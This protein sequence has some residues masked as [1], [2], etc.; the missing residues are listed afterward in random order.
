M[1]KPCIVLATLLLLTACMRGVVY[2]HYEHT[3]VSGW[4]KIDTLSYSVPRLAEGGLYDVT[5]GLRVNSKYP[6]QS[7]TLIVEQQAFPSKKTHI[8]TLNCV[9]TDKKG[10]VKGNGISHFQYNFRVSELHMEANDSLQI[11]VRHDMKREILPGISDVGICVSK[12][13]FDTGSR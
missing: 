4:E 6:F 8:D 3:V 2:D 5:L 13:T 7:L 10:K 11:T 9:L 1:K 12:A